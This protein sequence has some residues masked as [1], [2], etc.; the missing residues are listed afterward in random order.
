MTGPHQIRLSSSREK[1]LAAVAN[2]AAVRPPTVNATTADSLPDTPNVS[3]LA[4]GAAAAYASFGRDSVAADTARV[5]FTATGTKTPILATVVAPA[6]DPGSATAAPIAGSRVAG[7]V[8]SALLVP[9]S[10]AGS[11]APQTAAFTTPT[12]LYLVDRRP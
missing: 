3:N 10:V 8:M 5:V 7:S 4:F 2:A 1:S 6:G 12:V 11:T 9:R